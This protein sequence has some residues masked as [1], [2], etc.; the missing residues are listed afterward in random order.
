MM[1]TTIQTLTY[2]QWCEMYPIKITAEAEAE[3]KLYHSLDVASE[4]EAARQEGY[5]FY[6]AHIQEKHHAET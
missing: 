3:L 1:S 6:L 2:E 4:I 5:K